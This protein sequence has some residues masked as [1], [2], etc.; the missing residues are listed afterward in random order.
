MPRLGLRPLPHRHRGAARAGLARPGDRLPAGRR[1][2]QHLEPGAGPRGR[3]GRRRRGPRLPPQ[4]PGRGRAQRLGA[5]GQPAARPALGPQRGGL[6]RGPVADRRAGHRLRAAGCAATTPTCCRPRRRSS[7]SSAT[8]TRPT[9][10]PPPAT[11]RPRVLHEYEL[12]AFRAADRRRRGGRRDGL[13]QPGQRPPGAPE[14]A[15]STT[16]CGGWTAD[17]RAGGQRRRGAH[18]P[19]RAAQAYYADHVAE[20]TPPRCRAGVDSFTEDDDRP[21]ATVGRLTEALDRGLLDRGRHR[22]RGAAHA[23]DPVPA[24]RVRPGRAR[25]V[26]RRSPRRSSTAPRTRRWPARPPASRSCCC[27]NDGAAAAARRPGDRGSR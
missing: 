22:P 3:R 4:G 13:V 9:A 6:L 10:A 12:P 14:P 20:P 24:R 17:E 27:S 18:Q 11:C 25:P 7:T 15:A 5:G 23:A 8:T 21:R 26:R 16:S 1:A 2:G 19:G